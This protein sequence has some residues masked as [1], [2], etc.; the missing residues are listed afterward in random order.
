MD[1]QAKHFQQEQELQRQKA[2]KEK[3]DTQNDVE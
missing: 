1:K 3:Q 2:E